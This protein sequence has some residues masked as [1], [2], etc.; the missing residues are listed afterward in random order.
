MSLLK[1]MDSLLLAAGLLFGMLLPTLSTA[2]AQERVDA[3]L[4]APPVIALITEH[5]DKINPDR[6]PARSAIVGDKTRQRKFYMSPRS[7]CTKLE[8]PLPAG[9]ETGASRRGDVLGGSSEVGAAT[10]RNVLIRFNLLK[11]SP[12][13]RP[14]SF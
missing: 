10:F 7:R 8:A 11:T 2:T 14:D 3:R 4:I 6:I 9:C 13:G 12:F 1:R 5:V